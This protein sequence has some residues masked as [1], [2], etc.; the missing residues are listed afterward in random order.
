[1]AI[2]QLFMRHTDIAAIP[3]L[4][5][6]NGIE[7]VRHCDDMESQ[8]EE[9]IKKAFGTRYSFEAMI[10]NGGDYAPDK[11]LYLRTAG[12]LV[13]TTTAVEK[14]MFPGEGWIRMVGVDPDYRGMGFGRLI[15]V[16]ALESL[17]QRGY[18]TAVLSTDDD[19]LSAIR[20]YYSMGFRPIITHESHKERWEK[21]MPLLEK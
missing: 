13:A 5:L 12:R 7:L 16:A 11:V 18:K 2:P 10:K 20:L 8:W 14:D 17:C 1:M 4:S 9:L 21:I 19:R 15:V 6:P 3:R